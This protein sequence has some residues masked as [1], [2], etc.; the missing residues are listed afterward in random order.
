MAQLYK[1]TK[2]ILEIEPRNGQQFILSEVQDLMGQ[3]VI[4]T[5]RIDENLRMLYFEDALPR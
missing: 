1:T 2:E 3:G 4:R 5:L